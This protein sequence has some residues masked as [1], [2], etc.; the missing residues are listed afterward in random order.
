MHVCFRAAQTL[1]S[2]SPQAVFVMVARSG[3]DCQMGGAKESNAKCGTRRNVEKD[4][5]ADRVDPS[6]VKQEERSDA[7][8]REVP[9]RSA[10]EGVQLT[11]AVAASQEGADA[12]AEGDSYSDSSD[13]SVSDLY[14]RPR[15]A[16]SPWSGSEGPYEPDHW[17]SDDGGRR[18]HKAR[19][20]WRTAR[21]RSGGHGKGGR[22]SRRDASTTD[23]LLAWKSGSRSDAFAERGSCRR[24]KRRNPKSS[25]S[26][27]SGGERSQR[28]GGKANTRSRGCNPLP[29]RPPF[30]LP[31]RRLAAVPKHTSATVNHEAAVAAMHG[32]CVPDPL[33]LLIS[34][35][36]HEVAVATMQGATPGQPP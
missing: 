13:L 31:L 15:R 32:A 23:D 8:E 7:G 34:E 1:C 26:D 27:P 33:P 29:R 20:R 19:S 6:K 24:P 25:V 14:P 22:P 16:R 4:D 12:D 10:E 30:T 36:H 2:L 17:W 3:A 35:H 21:S 9:K 11:A 18:S 28:G 5:A